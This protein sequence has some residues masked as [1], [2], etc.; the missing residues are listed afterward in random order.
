MLIDFAKHKRITLMDSDTMEFLCEVDIAE[1]ER[2]PKGS[3]WIRLYQRASGRLAEDPEMTATAFR[4]FHFLLFRM[5]YGNALKFTQS[6]IAKHIGSSERSVFSA[7]RLLLQKNV[8]TKHEANGSCFYRINPNF[9]WKGEH[10]L[11]NIVL[12]ATA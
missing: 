11:R 5:G 3:D 9:A 12:Q 2:I 10:K 8:I 6:D 4:V 7:I 1:R